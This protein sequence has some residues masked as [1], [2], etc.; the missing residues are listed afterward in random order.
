VF[1]HGPVA[2]GKLTIARELSGMTGLPLFHNH[3]AVDLLLPLFPFGSPR[4][5]EHRERLWLSLI[6]DAAAA[7]TSLLFTFNPERT[8]SPEFPGALAARAATAGARVSFVELVCA[9][10]EIERRIGAASRRDFRK[11]TS[12]DQYRA[13]KRDG[14]F[15]YPPIESELRLDTSSATPA[16]SALRIAVGLGLPRAR[17]T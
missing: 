3:L 6:G 16:E 7:G 11:I 9:E 17:G 1:I 13:L 10:A 8:V 5:V 14:A 15:D 4:F 12:L 2:S